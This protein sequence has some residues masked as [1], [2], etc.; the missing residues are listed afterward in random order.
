MGGVAP[1]H[2]GILGVTRTS[3]KLL[4][5]LKDFEMSEQEWSSERLN[6]CDVGYISVVCNRGAA[7]NMYVRTRGKL[8]WNIWARRWGGRWSFHLREHQKRRIR[9]PSIR[10]T[11]FPL[12]IWAKTLKPNGSE[13][14]KMKS[15]IWGVTK[16]SAL[17]SLPAHIY[18]K[19]NLPELLG[20]RRVWPTSLTSVTSTQL[21]EA[22]KIELW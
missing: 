8:S 6:T 20:N 22:S 16:G 5:Q 1:T 12:L 9:M 13:Q 2:Y 19:P 10:H 21:S 11:D 14:A 3:V 17:C 15:H 4:W 18:L 7:A